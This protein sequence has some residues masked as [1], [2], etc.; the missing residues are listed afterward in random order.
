MESLLRVWQICG[1][2]KRGV[3]PLIPISRSAWWAGVSEGKYP[4]GI[5]LSTRTRVWPASSIQK[6]IEDLAA[7]EAAL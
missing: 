6:L 4:P 2:R 7:T 1:C 5:L 3:S